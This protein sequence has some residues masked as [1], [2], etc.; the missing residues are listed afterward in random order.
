MKQNTRP[1]APPLGTLILQEKWAPP[2][3]YVA[4][5]VKGTVDYRTT[6]QTLAK[7]A[8]LDWVHQNIKEGFDFDYD[9]QSHSPT[10]R[11]ETTS[12][13]TY[14]EILLVDFGTLNNA[15][16]YDTT[17]GLGLRGAHPI[18]MLSVMLGYPNFP[19]CIL[20]PGL[21]S[22]CIDLDDCEDPPSVLSR[23]TDAP[24]C[25]SRG[26]DIL[27]LFTDKRGRRCLSP[28]PGHEP[29]PGPHRYACVRCK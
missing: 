2:P 12:P 10:F 8:K 20:A 24:P 1:V 3:Q 27:C 6:I 28:W 11:K 13:I 29:W 22:N 23:V 16:R 5:V 18:E 15:E 7:K 25:H 19:F 26:G 14:K 21:E 17:I 9:R 4:L